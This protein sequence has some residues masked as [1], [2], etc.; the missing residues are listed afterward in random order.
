L[1]AA[2]HLFFGMWRVYGTSILGLILV[3]L[4]E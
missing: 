1:F 4:A 2:A 3:G